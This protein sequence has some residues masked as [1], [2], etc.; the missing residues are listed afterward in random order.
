M[1]GLEMLGE[2]SMRK[3]LWIIPAL[4]AVLLVVFGMGSV[5]SAHDP[6]GPL[7]QNGIDDDNDGTRDWDG[8]HGAYPPDPDC[9][10]PEDNTES[11]PPA[12]NDGVDND[13]DGKYDFINDGDDDGAASSADDGDPGCNGVNDNN[14]TDAPPPPPPPVCN[15][16]ADNDGDGKYDFSGD[17]NDDGAPGP[18]D[19]GDPGCTSSSDSSETD[20]PPPPPPPVCNDGTDN[21][22]DGKIDYVNDGNDD[23]NL[24][25]A[26][27]GDPGCTSSSDSSETDAPPPPPPPAACNDGTDN[28]GDG[29]I[30]YVSDGNDDGAPGTADDGDAGC[31]SSADTT[32]N[33]P[34]KQTTCGD[35]DGDGKNHSN[36]APKE[37]E[38]GPISGLIHG[39]HDA[40]RNGGLGPELNC[41][42]IA[43]M[44]GL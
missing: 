32:E 29:K 15:D 12:C 21:D 16:G 39:M 34:K 9:V 28:D 4:L 43:G 11:P 14:E 13:G 17:G 2:G 19:D 5:V 41:W 10:G 26:D 22:G 27:D 24:G 6:D 25:N 36:R 42:I 33:G 31:T 37:N 35:P 44:L 20:P 1:R 18:A 8:F 30:D 38:D 3:R 23:G 40:D 7:C